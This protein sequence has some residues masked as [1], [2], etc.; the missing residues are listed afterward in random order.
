MATVLRIKTLEGLSYDFDQYEIGRSREW[1]AQTQIKHESQ[2]GDPTVFNVGVEHYRAQFDFINTFT[3]TIARMNLVRQIGDRFWLYPHF[4][5]D[6]D[7]KYCV[8]LW[9][10]EAISE[11]WYHG[12]PLADQTVRLEFREFV[13]MA[14]YPPA[15]GS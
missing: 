8:V 11:F 13:G 3:S 15:P 2:C 6:T 12:Y 7:L 9:N 4:L 10:P 14:C 5:S 1:T